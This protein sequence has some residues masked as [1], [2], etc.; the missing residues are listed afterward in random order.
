MDAWRREK[1]YRCGGRAFLFRSSA[2]RRAQCFTARSYSSDGSMH[3]LRDGGEF[4]IYYRRFSI[5]YRR[6]AILYRRREADEEITGTST[7]IEGD[8]QEEGPE[9]EDGG[10]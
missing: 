3:P 8:G 1:T 2:S 5:L 7:A 6:F 10:E 9:G 4:S